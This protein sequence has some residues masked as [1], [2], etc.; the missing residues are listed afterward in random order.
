MLNELFAEESFFRR[1][2]FNDVQPLNAELKPL[3]PILVRFDKS[4]VVNDLQLM[5]ATLNVKDDEMLVNPDKSMEVKELSRNAAYIPLF[6]IL[7]TLDKST[8]VNEVQP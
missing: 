1:T 7:I 2:V 5:K 8:L 6:P 3:L 4:T